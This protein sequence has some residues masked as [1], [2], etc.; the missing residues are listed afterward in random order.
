MSASRHRWLVA[1]AV[2]ACMAG[3]GPACAA[4]PNDAAAWAQLT[5]AQK[6]SLSP[7]QRDWSLIDAPQRAKWLEVAA[8]FPTLPADERARLQERMAEWARMTPAERS[9]ARMQFQEAKQV[10]PS[11]RQA[12]W[13]A[14]QAL[15][16]AERQA[17]TQRAKPAANK[18]AP[19]MASPAAAGAGPGADAGK[20]NLVQTTPTPRAR[21]ATPTAQQNRPGATTTPMTAR[22]LPPV[23]NQ[24]GMPKIVATPGF[25]DAATLLPK[26]GPQGAAVRSAAVPSEPAARP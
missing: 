12:K 15:P 13:Q 11:D 22:A 6:Q 20:K 17:L 10:S 19:V 25:V 2:A 7:L 8:R 14:Y 26:R 23:H 24:A 4:A 5:S 3:A 16:E 1:L 18:P 21:A 9:R